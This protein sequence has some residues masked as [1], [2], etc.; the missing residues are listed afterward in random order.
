MDHV[1]GF[2]HGW[3]RVAE[4]EVTQHALSWSKEVSGGDHWRVTSEE[5]QDSVGKRPSIAQP[6]RI[7]RHGS[8]SLALC[9][10]AS[11]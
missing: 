5:G 11:H 6:H 3:E 9:Y 8:D 10:L 4:P 7:I 2:G 1:E